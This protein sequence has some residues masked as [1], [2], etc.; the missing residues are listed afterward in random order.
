MAIEVELP[1]GDIVEFPDGTSNA[2]MEKALKQYKPKKQAS[3]QELQARMYAGD[4]E[5]AAEFQSRYKVTTGQDYVPETGALKD[6]GSFGGANFN[7]AMG[8]TL[9]DTVNGMTQY[10]AE[11]GPMG[12]MIEAGFEAAGFKQPE[13]P[14]KTW[15]QK[16]IAEKREL[17]APLMESEGGTRGA[18]AGNVMQLAS[19]GAVGKLASIKYPAMASMTTGVAPATYKG[20]AM[21]GGVMGAVQPRVEGE[22]QAKNIGFGALFGTGGRAVAGGV[23]NV[24]SGLSKK[25]SPEVLKLYQAAKDAGIPVHWSQ[26]TDS[27]F[28]KTL[29]SIAGSLPFSGAGAAVK[30]QKDKFVSA[31]GET[32]GLKGATNLDD[33]VM[34]DAGKAISQKFTDVYGRNTI[35]ADAQLFVKLGQV[36][37]KIESDLTAD[38]AKIALNQINKIV[39]EMKSGVMTGKKYQ[40]LRGDLAQI[41]TSN[42]GTTLGSA[43][44]QARRALDEAAQRSVGQADGAIISRANREWANYKLVQKALKQVAGARGEVNPAN[45]WN[46]VKNGSTREMR[47]LGKIGQFIKDPIPDSGTAGRLMAGGIATGGAWTGGAAALPS[48]A[49]LIGTGAT[50]GRALNSPA[51]GR[52]MAEGL[53]PL[54]NRTAQGTGTLAKLIASGGGNKT[55]PNKPMNRSYEIQQTAM[56][57]P[58]RGPEILSRL[59]ES[60]QR[61]AAIEFARA[62]GLDAQQVLRKV[63]EEAFRVSRL[64]SVA[65]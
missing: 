16:R 58:D 22:S 30:N 20:N 1:N 25:L 53:G 14:V 62:H 34:A 52:Y 27:K 33:A 24:A 47:E 19:P 9:G 4:P 37:K 56:K 26:L 11:S 2:V 5:A 13:T 51:F 31:L 38:N 8:S 15:I 61:K 12:N 42:E 21:L 6:D 46:L 28:A 59:P 54:A 44:K 10:L 7:A 63:Q 18:I 32:F 50:A 40:N 57:Y 39:S 35:K 48:I 41:V 36:K 17:D 45:M 49:A 65:N 3:P 60:E 29:S 64:M 55:L 43:V 23:N